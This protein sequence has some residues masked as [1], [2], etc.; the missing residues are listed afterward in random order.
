MILSPGEGRN[1]SFSGG[2]REVRGGSALGGVMDRTRDIW[3]EQ[4]QGRLEAEALEAL[5][6]AMVACTAH[7]RGG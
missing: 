4:T 6:C 7:G 5:G 2:S 1:A 3:D